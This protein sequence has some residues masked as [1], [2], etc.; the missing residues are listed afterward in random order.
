MRAKQQI[1]DDGLYEFNALKQALENSFNS[2][3]ELC[4]FIERNIDNFTNELGYKYHSHQ[5]EYPL[6]NWTKKSKGSKRLDFLIK[7]KCGKLIAIEC[8]HP[9]Y[10]SELCAGIGQ[11]LS[12]ITLFKHHNKNID[13]FIIVS[14][15]ID[16]LVPAVISEFNLPISFIALDKFK[17]LLWQG[18]RKN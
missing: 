18:Q 13:K 9:K 7:T 10:I 6:L 1:L 12:Y 11:V 5:R 4:A 16:D 14:S 3:K 17:V 2:E 8:K 15:K